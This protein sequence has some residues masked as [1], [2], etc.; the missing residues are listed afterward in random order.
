M[1]Y[2][3][4]EDNDNHRIWIAVQKELEYYGLRRFEIET[5]FKNTGMESY[6]DGKVIISVPSGFI[7]KWLE[8][9][10]YH[11]A[12]INSLRSIL[13][14]EIKSIKYRNRAEF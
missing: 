8:K 7:K 14:M 5:W 11:K 1:K 6:E 2:Y 3:P 4:L 10:K 13:R 12:I 9:E